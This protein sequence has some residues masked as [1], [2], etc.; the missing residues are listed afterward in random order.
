[1]SIPIWAN[2]CLLFCPG[3]LRKLVG[4]VFSL[5][6]KNWKIKGSVPT[7]VEKNT[8]EP[9]GEDIVLKKR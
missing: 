5:S 4:C 6:H 7:E 3:D 9:K 2:H 1:M 8:G